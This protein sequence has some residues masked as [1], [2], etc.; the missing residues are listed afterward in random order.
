MFPR[1]RNIRGPDNPPLGPRALQP[2]N[3]PPP[4]RW[5][6]TNSQ[7]HQKAHT[8]MQTPHPWPGPEQWAKAALAMLAAETTAARRAGRTALA[9]DL[10]AL[11]EKTKAA[12]T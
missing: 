10:T 8:V 3:T 4:R 11:H 1:S 12:L 5:R 9:D 2:H 6:H 7:L